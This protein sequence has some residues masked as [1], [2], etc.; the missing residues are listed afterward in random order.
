MATTV[1]CAI[2]ACST[3][4]GPETTCTAAPACDQQHTQVASGEECPAGETCYTREKCDVSILCYAPQTCDAEPECK[5]GETKVAS[6]TD[7]LQDD[8]VC[9]E[10]EACGNTAWCTSGADNCTAIPTC[11]EGETEVATEADCP[12]DTSCKKAEMC[13]AVIWC[14]SGGDNCAAVPTCGEGET[15][16]ATEADCP[17]DT[18]C[19]K[20]EECGAVIW[21]WSGGDNCAAVPTCGEGETEVA[22]E[23][24]CPADTSCKKVEECGAVIWCWSGGCSA[25]CSEGDEKIAGS[26]DCLQDVACYEVTDC[27]ETIWC[28]GATGPAPETRL[29]A[30]GWS[31]G[32]CIGSCKTDVT[33][34]GTTVSLT[35]SGWDNTIYAENS[36]TL[37]DTVAGL[38]KAIAEALIGTDLQETYGCPDCADGGASYI[39]LIREDAESTH[40]YEYSDAPEALADA[41]AFIASIAAALQSCSA[42]SGVTPGDDCEP[43]TP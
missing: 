18:S 24:E 30:G 1:A 28:T 4:A 5:A 3:D 7:C 23:A 2:G 16:V 43:Y 15:E 13:G 42:E 14:W 12:A 29:S 17:A 26:D 22:T 36:G 34:E 33:I 10:V 40:N 31:F 35:I 21:C 20:V 9:Y 27:G 41:D 11:G 32:E 6:Q 38:P 39:T 25:Q 8:A 37:D 19:K